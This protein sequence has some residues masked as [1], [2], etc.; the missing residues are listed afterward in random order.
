MQIRNANPLS[1]MNDPTVQEPPAA[2][3]ASAV[4]MAARLAKTPLAIADAHQAGAPLMF[5]NDAFAALV[6]EDAGQLVGRPLA[7]LGMPALD[8]PV[9][10]TCRF[11]LV[12]NGGDAVPV[13][14]STSAVEAADGVPFCLLCSLVQ[15]RGEGADDAIARDAALLQEVALAAADLMREAA[16][17]A[18]LGP[19]EAPD[20]AAARIALGAL[21][22][23]TA[24]T[25]PSPAGA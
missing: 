10:G 4:I 21:Q 15:A 17:A 3:P 1:T 18:G 9:P 19:T 16:R 25:A 8:V 22:D 13:A 24:P 6:G 20:D 23:R 11:D 5:A 7:S 12:T 14:L 2:C